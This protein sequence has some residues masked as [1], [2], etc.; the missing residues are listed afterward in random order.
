MIRELKSSHSYAKVM[1]IL[2]VATLLFGLGYCLFG[3]LLLPFAISSL[4]ALFVFEKPSKRFLSYLIPPIPVII[5]VSLYGT[6]ALITVQYIFYALILAL[7]YR[8]SKTKATAAFY[9]TFL[10]ALFTVASLYISGA[11]AAESFLP[12]AVT[13]YYSDGYTELKARLVAYLSEYTVTANDGSIQKPVSAEAAGE[14]IDMA[15]EL[16]VS[17]VG[18]LAFLI[19]GISIKLFKALILHFSKNGIL[20]SFSHFLPSNTAAYVYVVVS[21][22]SIFVGTSDVIDL[23]ILNL[24]QILMCVFAYMGFQYVLM[25]GKITGRKTTVI[26]GLIAAILLLNT[27]A[28]QILS[29][30]GAWITIGTNKS[31]RSVDED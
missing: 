8:F 3:E 20:K 16:A 25:L 19:A 10:I 1:F 14:I 12:K 26:L 9:L 30:L 24:A 27:L 28:L 22:L 29:Y 11:I 17:F 2:S 23:T 4:A 31:L 18:I 15:S 7:V 13:D 21:I 5:A 6:F